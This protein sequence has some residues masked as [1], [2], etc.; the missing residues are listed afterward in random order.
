MQCDT[1]A[2]TTIEVNSVFSLRKVPFKS[3][4]PTKTRTGK[5]HVSAKVGENLH[6]LMNFCKGKPP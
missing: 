4:F 6:V 2:G 3:F 5:L 1:T